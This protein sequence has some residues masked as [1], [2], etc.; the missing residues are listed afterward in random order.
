MGCLKE[1]EDC[2]DEKAERER[3]ECIILYGRMCITF[4]TEYQWTMVGS[5][6]SVGHRHY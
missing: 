5:G 4:G 3:V 6:K 2:L 1:R